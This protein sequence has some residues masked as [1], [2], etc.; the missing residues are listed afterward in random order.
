MGP[1]IISNM[2]ERL[3]AVKDSLATAMPTR[4]VTRELKH[5]DEHS[6]AEIAAGVLMVTSRNERDYSQSLGMVAKEGTQKLLLI[7]HIKAAESVSGEA[8]EDAEIA[9]IEELK[10][11]LRITVP[12]VGLRLTSVEHSGQIDKPYGWLVASVDAGPPDMNTN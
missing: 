6:D 8:L 3:N 1:E 11:A 12:G 10:A 4:T 7:G 9:F 5:F 2:S